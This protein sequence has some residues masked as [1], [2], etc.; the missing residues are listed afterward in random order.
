MDQRQE[1]AEGDGVDGDRDPELGRFQPGGRTGDDPAVDR[2]PGQ[3]D[4]QADQADERG[5]CEDRTARARKGRPDPRG[6]GVGER[7][8]SSLAGHPRVRKGPLGGT[9]SLPRT[10]A[11]S[12]Q[13]TRWDGP[14]DESQPRWSPYASGMSAAAASEAPPASAPASAQATQQAPQLRRYAGA[15]VGAAAL[16]LAEGPRTIPVLLAV[17]VA[18]G[19]WAVLLRGMRLPILPFAAWAIAP[20]I[21]LVAA[22]ANAA[23]MFLVTVAVSH[24]SSRTSSRATVTAVT[25]AGAS[26]I[27]LHPRPADSLHE[28]LTD[29]SAYFAFGVIFGSLVGMQLRRASLLTEELRA[30]QEQLAEVAAAQERR[31]IARD[32]HDIVGHSLSVVLLHVAGARRLIGIDPGAAE[33]ALLD[34]ERVGRESLDAVREVVGLLRDAG[35]EPRAQPLAGSTFDLGEVTEAFRRAGGRV[36]LGLDG[37]PD[38]LPAPAQVTVYR[39]IQEALT[40]AGRHGIPGAVATVSVHIRRDAVVVEARNPVEPGRPGPWPV[41]RV[42]ASGGG[43]GLQGMRERVGALGGELRA[44]RDAGEWVVSCRVPLGAGSPS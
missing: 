7:H 30:A 21:Y 19:P 4:Q 17:I 10:G 18:L 34:A 2:Q 20:A 14:W 29:G 40:N 1:R 27:L 33:Q 22:Q 3:G 42:G 35:P 24:V 28:A 16:T 26:V 43:H 11:L 36:E 32:V 6:R 39:F 31:R 9:T 13:G 15:A 8:G 25:L 12:A 38:T 44:G 41:D 23:S 37:E 5:G